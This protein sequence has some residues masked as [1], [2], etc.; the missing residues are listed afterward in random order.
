ME[1]KQLFVLILFG[2]MLIEALKRVFTADKILYV[3]NIA[4]F[5]LGAFIALGFRVDLFE[6]VGL[7]VYVPWIGVILNT[8]F[9]GVGFMEGTG[10]IYDFLN[11]AQQIVF[12][13]AKNGRAG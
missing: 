12:N 10:Y 13:I 11:A 8:L 9:L 2:E 3:Q 4:A 5:I 1:P 6:M 7:T